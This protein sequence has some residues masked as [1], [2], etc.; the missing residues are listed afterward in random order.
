MV[1]I[2][3]FGL[4]AS[5]GLRALNTTASTASNSTSLNVS[6]KSSTPGIGWVTVTKAVDPVVTTIY[7]AHN[8]TTMLSPV[9]LKTI[10]S[11]V[12][13]ITPGATKAASVSSTIEPQPSRVAPVVSSNLTSSHAATV[14]RECTRFNT[15][16]PHPTSTGDNLAAQA[17]NSTVKMDD[18]VTM[19]MLQN[20]CPIDVLNTGLNG[21]KKSSEQCT[22]LR[23][24]DND[25]KLLAAPFGPSLK[26]K[27]IRTVFNVITSTMKSDGCVPVVT[28]NSVVSDSPKTVSSAPASKTASPT[29]AYKADKR[30]HVKGHIDAVTMTFVS[31]HLT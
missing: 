30:S 9:I 23:Y 13:T 10:F 2:H 14:T 24:I 16:L 5:A 29:A 19:T 6:T 31:D 20:G 22:V 1:A 17:A 25:G 27:H 4:M 8:S 7:P 26:N 11:G 12:T 18:V 28:E 21:R 15:V 3:N